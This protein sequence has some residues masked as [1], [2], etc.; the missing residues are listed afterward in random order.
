VRQCREAAAVL[1]IDSLRDATHEVMRTY[2][3]QLGDVLLRRVRHVVTENERVTA[4]TAALAPIDRSRIREL[5]DESHASL[6][7]DYEVSTP[8]IDV[9]QRCAVDSEGVI[10]A[11]LTG[12]GFGGCIVALVDKDGADASAAEVKQRYQAASGRDVRAWVSPPADGAR[13]S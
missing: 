7:N 5:F 6:R 13:R 10:G 2:E 11:R 12:G 8:E 9:L 1:G 3:H 4:T